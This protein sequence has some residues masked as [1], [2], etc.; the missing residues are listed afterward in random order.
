MCRSRTRSWI[1]AA[2]RNESPPTSDC[3]P[4]E[5]RRQVARFADSCWRN[6]RLGPLE[7]DAPELGPYA[8]PVRIPRL[9]SRRAPKEE[10]VAVGDPRLDGWETVSTFED[11]RTAIAW[12]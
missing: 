4:S 6:R 11:Q 1:D 8:W 12:R 3:H 2:V 9:R 10:P 7:P 5:C